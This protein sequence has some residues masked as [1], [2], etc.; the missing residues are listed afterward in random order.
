M[1]CI[2]WVAHAWPWHGH[3]CGVCVWMARMWAARVGGA[4][5]G[6]I[7]LGSARGCASEGARMHASGPGMGLVV[8]VPLGL[9]YWTTEAR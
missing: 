7:A 4:V 1:G 3:G 8:R 2:M 6:A 5:G 9:S